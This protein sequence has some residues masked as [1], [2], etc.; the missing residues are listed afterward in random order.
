[1]DTIK[2]FERLLLV[3]RRLAATGLP[4]VLNYMYKHRS[5]FIVLHRTD[6]DKSYYSLT[7]DATT[8]SI[9]AAAHELCEPTFTPVTKVCFDMLASTFWLDKLTEVTVESITSDG[10]QVLGTDINELVSHTRLFI[11]E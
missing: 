3:N 11:K 4:V 6:I 9:I 10:V 5:N 1:M 8:D 7:L 2:Q